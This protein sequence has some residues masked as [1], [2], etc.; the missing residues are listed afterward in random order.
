MTERINDLSLRDSVCI[1][2]EKVFSKMEKLGL[3]RKDLARKID[4]N[5]RSMLNALRA[6]KIS[7]FFLISIGRALDE[8]PEWL[9]DLTDTAVNDFD[10]PHDFSAYLKRV[11]RQSTTPF[12]FV[13]ETLFFMCVEPEKLSKEQWVDLSVAIYKAASEKLREWG[14]R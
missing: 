2:S 4:M 8:D 7:S 10:L 3:S 12:S 5:Y 6:G 1:N 11:R 13:T 14:L 9:Q